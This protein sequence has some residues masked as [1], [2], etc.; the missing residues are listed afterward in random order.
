MDPVLL[1]NVL[2]WQLISDEHDLFRSSIYSGVNEDTSLI[3]ALMFLNVNGYV[4][5]HSLLNARGHY[6]THD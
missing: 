5:L 2:R 6:D 1:K 4:C 3:L